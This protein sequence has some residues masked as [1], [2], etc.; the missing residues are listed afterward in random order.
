MLTAASGCVY[1]VGY[2]GRSSSGRAVG[3]V[4]RKSAAEGHGQAAE[5]RSV[6]DTEGATNANA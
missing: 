4:I 6:I 3:R 1:H 5:G 2:C